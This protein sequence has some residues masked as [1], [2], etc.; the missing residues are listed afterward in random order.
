MRWL[1]S[2]PMVAFDVETT[3]VDVEADRIVTAA[4]TRLQPK[5]IGWPWQVDTQTWLL[6]PGVDIPPEA[7]AIHGVTTE[8]AKTNGDDPTK[9]LDYITTLL[10]RCLVN[11]WPLI[12]YNLAYDLTILDRELRRHDLPPLDTRLGRPV[13]P[14]VDPYVLDKHIDPYR[15]GS[16][17]LTE[18]CRH[19][20]ARLDAAHD[21]AADA[22]AAARLAY[23]VAQLATGV[24]PDCP[25]ATR[26]TDADN[27]PIREALAELG[28]LGKTELH[29]AQIGWRA[30]QMASL[31]DYFRAK[32]QPA[33]DVDGQWPQR[34]W[35][36][37]G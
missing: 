36:E 24:M 22:L 27:G 21:A 4:I 31:A 12:G 25:A 20:D 10:I 5:I 19:Y 29:Q 32:D 28:A 26:A 7:T 3:G 9:A 6:D 1:L 37:P 34:A 23:R 14:C 16:R 17:K 11:R 18:M 30:E 35:K 2:S 8:H 33:D 15:R 13:A